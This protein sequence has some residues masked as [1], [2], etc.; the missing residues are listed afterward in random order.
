MT[1]AVC[2]ERFDHSIFN[3]ERITLLQN[4]LT[5]VTCTFLRCSGLMNKDRAKNL[6]IFLHSM[7]LKHCKK[8]SMWWID[9]KDVYL[10]HTRSLQKTKRVALLM[11]I[12]PMVHKVGLEFS[13]CLSLAGPH[14][15]A[16]EDSPSSS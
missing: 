1:A 7:F 4:D 5:A 11:A 13:Q 2:K 12:L 6:I 10:P 3:S 8:P 9:T 15:N 16:V 14:S